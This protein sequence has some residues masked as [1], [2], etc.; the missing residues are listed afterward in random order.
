MNIDLEAIME[1]VRLG[2]C[3]CVPELL[4]EVER[5]TEAQRRAVAQLFLLYQDMDAE[6]G[7]NPFQSRLLD[8]TRN[9]ESGTGQP[10]A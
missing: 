8:I 10:L 7:G 5:L 3:G 9:L 1:H 6:K 4:A 2:G